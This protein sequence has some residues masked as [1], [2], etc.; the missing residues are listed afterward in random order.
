MDDVTK[1]K[2]SSAGGKPLTLQE[3]AR[4]TAAFPKMAVAK[5]VGDWSEAALTGVFFSLSEDQDPS[6]LGV[7]MQW[8]TVDEVLDEAQNA[9][10]GIQASRL[11]LLPVGKCMLGSGDPYFV[12]TR[13][14]SGPIVRVPHNAVNADTDVLDESR[15]ERVSPSLDAFVQTSSVGLDQ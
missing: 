10:P 15:I 9:T 6:G 1:K 11:G 8:M 4:L 2:L 7:E 14:A 5:V 12:D 3:A 13:V